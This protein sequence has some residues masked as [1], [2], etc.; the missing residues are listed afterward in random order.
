MCVYIFHCMFFHAN[1]PCVYLWGFL[2]YG[3]R[4]EF[5]FTSISISINNKVIRSFFST[6]PL[7]NFH[8]GHLSFCT[9]WDCTHTCMPRMLGRGTCFHIQLCAPSCES[10][11]SIFSM[12]R[13][14]CQV[15]RSVFK[16]FRVGRLPCH[17]C[18]RVWATPF[19]FHDGAL[20]AVPGHFQHWCPLMFT[21][22]CVSAEWMHVCSKQ[23]ACGLVCSWRSAWHSACAQTEGMRGR[24]KTCYIYP[25]YA[26]LFQQLAYGPYLPAGLF[27][28]KALRELWT[29]ANMMCLVRHDFSE[30]ILESKHIDF[31]ENKNN[32]ALIWPILNGNSF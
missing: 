21:S 17:I 23:R 26:R 16:A 30:L 29:F 6:G 9:C 1:I 31:K 5:L 10:S 14:S 11:L 27:L 13:N 28:R 8:L 19:R 2:F 18:L 25:A 32:D 15:S 22:L 4:C 24:V 7:V 12:A 3:H 20:S